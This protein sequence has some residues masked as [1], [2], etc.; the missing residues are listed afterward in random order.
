MP[1]DM[2][3]SDMKNCIT[4][5]DR[6]LF[7]EMARLI[8]ELPTLANKLTRSDIRCTTDLANVLKKPEYAILWSAEAPEYLPK[9]AASIL[10]GSAF[11][12]QQELDFWKCF[13]CK[14]AVRFDHLFYRFLSL[15]V[16]EDYNQ[17]VSGASE[18]LLSQAVAGERAANRIL[19]TPAHTPF[20]VFSLLLLVAVSDHAW[21]VV[22][23]CATNKKGVW[24][25]VRN[26]VCKFS[27]TG[28]YVSN[29]DY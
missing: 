16:I 19:R 5:A 27:S 8:I 1:D 26:Y 20:F 22:C 11:C 9:E 2:F 4:V 18:V 25:G 17:I 23:H 6:R 15:R 29:I 24:A 12:K 14:Y 13:D 10:I 3:L 28:C 7:W 21:F